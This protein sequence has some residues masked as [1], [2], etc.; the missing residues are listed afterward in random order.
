M[1][2]QDVISCWIMQNILKG[3]VDYGLYFRFIFRL[4]LKMKYLIILDEI[5]L[6]CDDK[7]PEDRQIKPLKSLMNLHNMHD[8]SLRQKQLLLSSH[9]LLRSRSYFQFIKVILWDKVWVSGGVFRYISKQWVINA[10]GFF[11]L[12]SA[13]TE[14]LAAKE[15]SVHLLLSLLKFKIVKG[16][17][18]ALH[19]FHLT[20]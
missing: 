14:V 9:M 19:I 4:C 6:F 16:K 17:V 11:Y 8:L 5:L 7:I 2:F 12:S 20:P 13:F 10:V 3:L 1:D 18:Y 15:V